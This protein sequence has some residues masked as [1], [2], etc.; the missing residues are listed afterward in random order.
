MAT[1]SIRIMATSSARAKRVFRL[2]ILV[3]V[4]APVVIGVVKL[5]ITVPIMVLAMVV[6]AI[7]PATL[8]VA[9]QSQQQTT[10]LGVKIRL[11]KR[12]VRLQSLQ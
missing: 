2:R 5:S 11:A 7:F 1:I 6:R 4:V 9:L 10:L 12:F 8:V 3:L